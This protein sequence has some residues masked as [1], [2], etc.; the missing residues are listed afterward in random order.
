[1]SKNSMELTSTSLAKVNGIRRTR[2][3]TDNKNNS[4]RLDINVRDVY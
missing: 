3:R 1:M 4:D 2:Y